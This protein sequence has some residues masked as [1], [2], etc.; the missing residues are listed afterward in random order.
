MGLEPSALPGQCT[1]IITGPV[2]PQ[3]SQSARTAVFRYQDDVT[4][5][6]TWAEAVVLLDGLSIDPEKIEFVS[7]LETIIYS[8]SRLFSDYLCL[9]RWNWHGLCD[10]SCGER[11]ICS[12]LLGGL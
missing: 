7:S 2:C 1:S 5:H 11:R 4:W 10:E 9:S 6:S 8:F 12:N 3:K